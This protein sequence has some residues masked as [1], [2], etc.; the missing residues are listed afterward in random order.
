[1]IL[2]QLGA[3]EP[4]PWSKTSHYCHVKGVDLL[5]LA[6]ILSVSL[7]GGDYLCFHLGP[8]IP[9]R[10]HDVVYDVDQSLFADFTVK[11]VYNL[12][13][14]NKVGLWSITVDATQ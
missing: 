7:G 1:M 6:T 12:Q 11:R 5:G 4:F 3:T 13:T 8:Q 9:Q 10:R 2:P 14:W